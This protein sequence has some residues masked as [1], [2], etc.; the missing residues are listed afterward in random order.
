[1]EDKGFDSEGFYRALEATVASRA[2]TW[3]QVG[4]ETGVS[5]STLTRMAQ[6]RKPD[7]ASLAALSA[8]AGL[9]PADFVTAPFKPLQA[10]TMARI[11]MLLR[12]DPKLDHQ[13]ADAL[14]AIVW[15]A[16]ERLRKEEPDSGPTTS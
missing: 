11:S 16:Y 6:G 7:A 9:N 8:W 10:E 2:L 12:S 13:G 1:M 4:V 14:E 3:K 15:A 5:A